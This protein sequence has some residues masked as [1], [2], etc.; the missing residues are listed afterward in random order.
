MTLRACIIGAGSSGIAAA[1]ILAGRGIPFDC[2]EKGSGIGGN[3]RFG[4]DNRMSSA[5]RSL[6]INTSKERSAYSD[7]P[8]PEDYPDFPHHSQLLEYFERYVDHFGVRDRITFETEVVR[9]EPDGDGAWRVTTRGRDGTTVTGR[10]GAVLVA[11]GHHWD[12]NHPEIPGRFDG[13]TLHSHVYE[14][15]EGFRDRRVLVVGVGNSGCDI[16]CELS[17]VAARAFLST[18]RGAHV[19]PKYLLGRPVDHWTTPLTSRLPF[20]VERQAFKLLLLLARGRQ[21]AFGFPTP[22]H[23][24]GS[25]HPTVS[26][27]LLDLI[28]H[29]RVTIKPDLDR[30]DGRRVHFVDGSAEEIDAIVYATGYRVSFP[31]FDREL[32]DPSGNRVPLYR[33]VVHPRLRNLYFLGLIQPFGAI[34]PLAEAQAEWVADLLE[35]AAGLPAA[36]V[37]ETRI[38]RDRKRLRRRFVASPRHT[39]EVDFYPYLRELARERRRGRRRAPNRALGAGG[40]P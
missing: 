39:L 29:G 35:G 31:F 5:Y 33:R 30:L 1:K 22:D 11:S 37:M 20:A 24:V 2:F 10:Y 18:R 38:E 21:Q 36:G 3:W 8:M 4:N 14:A 7:F 25:E 27:E 16:V 9:A 6:H 17:R 40:V 13:E 28:G 23:P 34:M 26:S 19:I 12:P 15:P 32:I